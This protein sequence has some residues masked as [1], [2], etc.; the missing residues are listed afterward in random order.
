MGSLT[1][2]VKDINNAI[3]WGIW[4]QISTASLAL[5]MIRHR[6]GVA[7]VVRMKS[8]G[9]AIEC[10]IRIE[11]EQFHSPKP[12]EK[13]PPAANQKGEPCSASR[14]FA[15]SGKHASLPEGAD[16]EVT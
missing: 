16:H 3:R 8:A 13:R 4:P 6:L 7:T 10:Q 11:S 15:C 14:T 1:A 5:T 2:V 12:A 9:G